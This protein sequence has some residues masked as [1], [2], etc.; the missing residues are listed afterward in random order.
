MLGQG[1]KHTETATQGRSALARAVSGA[2]RQ[3]F[4]GLRAPG[5]GGLIGDTPLP[6]SS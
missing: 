2:E 5:S 1:K 6:L 3:H 4:E